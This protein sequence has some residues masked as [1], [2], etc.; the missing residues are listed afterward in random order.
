[1][2]IGRAEPQIRSAAL[3]HR[4]GRL[5][6]ILR[7]G[8]SVAGPKGRECSADAAGQGIRNAVFERKVMNIGALVS[9]QFI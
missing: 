5:L 9:F 6:G 2:S 1:M 3:R 7:L 8:A 4:P